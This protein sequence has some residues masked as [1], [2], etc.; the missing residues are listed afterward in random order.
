MTP[1][2]NE[3]P[4]PTFSEVPAREIP[5]ELGPVIAPAPQAEIH[6]PPRVN[7]EFTEV[8][9]P[10]LNDENAPKPEVGRHDLSADAIRQRANRI[11]KPRA[12]GDLKVSQQI[13]DEWHSK[14]KA[15]RCLEQ[16]F[17]QVGYNPE[18]RMP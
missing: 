15:R 14:G 11:F 16:I 10:F 18:A 2:V 8:V 7:K 17:K 4:G 1:T 9:I 3:S 5:L 12:N 6:E 13:Y